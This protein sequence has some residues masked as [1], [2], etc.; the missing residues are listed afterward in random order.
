MS[1][2]SLL[3]HSSNLAGVQQGDGGVVVW[4]HDEGPHDIV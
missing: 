2:H 3:V 4:P 1:I